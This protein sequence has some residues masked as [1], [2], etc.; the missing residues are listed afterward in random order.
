MIQVAYTNSNCSDLW[1]MFQKQTKKHTDLPLYMISDK[2]VSNV[3]L[4]GLFIYNNE[5]P[6]YKVWVD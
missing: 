6:Y 5:D 3:N 1:D 2:E 4:S